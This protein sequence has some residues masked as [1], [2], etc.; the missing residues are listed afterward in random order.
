MICVHQAGVNTKLFIERWKIFVGLQ[1]LRTIRIQ[2]FKTEFVDQSTGGEILDQ[3]L[4]ST[5]S[6]GT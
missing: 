3:L 2:V 1:Q 6:M 4:N 5:V